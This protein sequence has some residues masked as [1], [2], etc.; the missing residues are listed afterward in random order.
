MIYLYYH[1]NRLKEKL[2]LYNYREISLLNFEYG[3]TSVVNNTNDENEE[4]LETDHR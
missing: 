4:T 1:L 3:E 2:D